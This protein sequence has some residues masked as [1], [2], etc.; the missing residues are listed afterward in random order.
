MECMILLKPKNKL[1]IC[2]YMNSCISVYVS[3]LHVCWCKHKKK[4]GKVVV[5]EVE[6][7]RERNHFHCLFYALSYII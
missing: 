4:T 6:V 3:S 5:S 7:E 2:N 1:H